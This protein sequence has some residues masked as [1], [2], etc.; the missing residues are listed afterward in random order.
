MLPP[1]ATF[2]TRLVE[3]RISTPHVYYRTETDVPLGDK[4]G[5]AIASAGLSLMGSAMKRVS[6]GLAPGIDMAIY[7]INRNMEADN[8]ARNTRT[9]PYV[10]DEYS[11]TSHYENYDFQYPDLTG[12]RLP[13]GVEFS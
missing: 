4:I 2:K 5:T 8:V 12:Y 1:T 11:Y 7:G 13:K 3:D 10:K 6:P 9:V